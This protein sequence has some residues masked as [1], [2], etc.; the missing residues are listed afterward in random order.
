MKKIVFAIA[1]SGIT[2]MACNST[3]NKNPE[4]NKTND[5]STTTHVSPFTSPVNG[6]LHI[7]LQMKN[8]FVND[9]DKGAA[10]AGNEMVKALNDFDKNILNDSERKQFADIADDMKENAE[11]IGANAGNIKHQR[12]HFDMLS[13]DLYDMVKTFAAGEQ[14]YVDYCPMY[15]DNKGAIWLAKTKEIKNPYFGKEMDTCGSIKEELK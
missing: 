10:D 15:N 7:Y 2:L 12:E 13:K 5:T 9:D 3:N 6:I 1:I 8:A 11:H 14:I 4:A